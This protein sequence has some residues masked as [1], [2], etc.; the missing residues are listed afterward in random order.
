MATTG[1]EYVICAPYIETDGVVTYEPGMVITHAIK[2]DLSINLN[3]AILY[4]DN[5][6]DESVKEFKD[7]KIT[8]NGSY[9]EYS[10]QA[11]LLGHEITGDAGK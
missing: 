2:A 8:I 1:L 11:M 10:A 9:L 6:V 4:A 5:K 7:G 3:D